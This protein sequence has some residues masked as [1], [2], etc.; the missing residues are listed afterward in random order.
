M[1]EPRARRLNACYSRPGWWQT[2][3]GLDAAN[4]GF[5]WTSDPE[6]AGCNRCQTR[7]ANGEHLSRKDSEYMVPKKTSQHR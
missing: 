4:Q 6:V 3:C 2:L 5:G 7:I 1:S